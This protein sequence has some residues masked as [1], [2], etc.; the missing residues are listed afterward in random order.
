MFEKWIFLC[1][2]VIIWSS[3][4]GQNYYSRSAKISFYS[5]A[6]MEKIEAHNYSASSIL[7]IESGQ[8]EFAVLIKGF[9]FKK[10]L[11]QQH[12]N[13]S[14]MESDKFPKA[15]FRGS[16]DPSQ[17]QQ[18]TPE[19]TIKVSGDITIKGISKPIE[20]KGILSSNGDGLKGTAS[21]E[22]DIADFGIK[23]PKVVRDNIADT[24]LITVEAPYEA[25][26]PK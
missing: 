23:I 6:P 10:A 22:L 21:F 17:I 18:S 26:E 3:V 8:L 7:D 2:A 25:F 13:E 14:Y 12:F 19:D 24:V 5:D 1:F 20:L 16:F 4:D 9:R 11:M 15:V